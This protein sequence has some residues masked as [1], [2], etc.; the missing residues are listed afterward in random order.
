MATRVMSFTGFPTISAD[1]LVCQIS[2]HVS[3]EK[4]V[5]PMNYSSEQIPPSCSMRHMALPVSDKAIIP[6]WTACKIYVRI[7]YTFHPW[8]IYTRIMIRSS[9]GVQGYHVVNIKALGP[10]KG[11][12]VLIII[13]YFQLQFYYWYQEHKFRKCIQMC[14][15]CNFIDDR[16][17]LV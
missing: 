16:S 10:W 9:K 6:E 14:V 2:W 11:T 3:N 1:S 17:L 5:K 15:P 8:A 7:I 4:C 13:W 12:T